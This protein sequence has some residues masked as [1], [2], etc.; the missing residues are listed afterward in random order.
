MLADILG[1]ILSRVEPEIIAAG[2]RRESVNSV[3]FYL[4][5][6]KGCDY[7]FYV[8]VYDEGATI[9]LG[10]NLVGADGAP[11][12]GPFWSRTWEEIA[13]TDQKEIMDARGLLE[14]VTSQPTR[15]E[16]NYGVFFRGFSLVVVGEAGEE[17]YRGRRFL[18]PINV[19]A[20]R[21]KDEYHCS[22]S[23]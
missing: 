3:L 4:P 22:P 17:V 7:R 12:R 5:C 14:R 2:E 20:I 13:S 8:G 23:D 10:A 11:I 18:R 19:A 1:L 9:E 15:I 21:G 6:H 16:R